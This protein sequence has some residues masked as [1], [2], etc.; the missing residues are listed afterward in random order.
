M[1]WWTVRSIEAQKREARFG[2]DDVGRKASLKQTIMIVDRHYELLAGRAQPNPGTL[3]AEC[4][5][6]VPSG[7]DVAHLTR[8]L[9][10]R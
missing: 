2:D 1:R 7:L 4:E 8:Y 10:A 6:E 3:G 9:F 5:G